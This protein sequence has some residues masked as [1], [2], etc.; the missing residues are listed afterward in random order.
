[1]STRNIFGNTTGFKALGNRAIPPVASQGNIVSNIQPWYRNPS[2]LPLPTVLSSEQKFVGLHAVYPNANFVSMLVSG[3]YTVDWGD[4]TI[5]NFSSGTQAN[6]E[7]S[8]SDADLNNTNAPVTFQDS[9]DTVTRNSHGYTN[10]MTVSFSSITTTTGIVAGQIYYVVGAT[11]NTFQVAAT[12]GGSA[13][14]LTDDG[15]GI[16]L[17]YKQAIVTVTPQ[18]GQSITSF[19][20]NV[21][22]PSFSNA[23]A[24]GW[25][26]IALSFPS[27]TTLQ[28]GAQTPS[29]RM[30][31]EQVSLINVQAV[32]SFSN[33]FRN[34]SLLRSIPVINSLNVTNT[35]SMFNTCTA[36]ETVPLFNTQ[37]AQNMTLMFNNCRSLTSV[38]LLNMSSATDASNMFATCSSLQTV[39]LFNFPATLSSTASMFTGCTSLQTVPLF[40]TSAVTGM[41]GMFINCS[42]LQTVPLF[43]TAS[44]QNMSGMF[45]GC[46]SLQTVP[47]FNTASVTNM[48]SMFNLCTSLQTVPLFNTSAVT[49][50]GSMFASC[51]SLVS[52]PLFNTSAATNMGGMFNGCTSLKSVPL[53]NT[54]AVT[55]FTNMFIS[56]TSLVSV[57]LFSM[58]SVVDIGGMFSG[59][60]SLQTVPLFNMRLTG[61]TGMGSLFSGCTALQTVP[62]INAVSISASSGFANMFTNCVSLSEM[63]MRNIRFTFTVANCKL[64][65]TALNQIYTNLPTVTG[66]T[67]TVTGN[68]GTATDN[69]AIATA[70]GWTV[71]G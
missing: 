28:M 21:R 27:C 30:I 1:M 26:D 33:L 59:C 20:L 12:L 40:N 8:F 41:G 62:A 17:P 63:D 42:S 60:T 24:A 44:V 11:T 70:K 61:V 50:M 68:Y 54:S 6:Y 55:F 52:V 37:N 16:I 4:G 29:V 25:L 46:T 15:T 53:F 3:A 7:Y 34:C 36:L 38:P 64:S 39:P 10:G 31:F 32:T 47:L 14:P 71:S 56:C 57:P 23:Y 67:I 58:T 66:Q 45:N 51:T 35:S 69:P 13:L 48:G 43:N 2:W 9:T 18:A 5:Q 49:S 65:A 22:N 19:N